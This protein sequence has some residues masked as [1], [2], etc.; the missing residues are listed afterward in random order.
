M[1]RCERDG[2]ASCVH[3]VVRHKFPVTAIAVSG[4][5]LFY[6]SSYAEDGEQHIHCRGF[7]QGNIL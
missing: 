7:V 4:S 5:R 2:Y 3:K 1:Q 6:A